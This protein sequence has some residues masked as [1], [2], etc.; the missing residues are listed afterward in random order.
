MCRQIPK[1][2]DL[3][4]LTIAFVTL[5]QVCTKT[6]A[7]DLPPTSTGLSV[8][9]DGS[10]ELQLEVFVNGTSSELIATFRQARDG[11]LLI[12]PDQLRNVGIKPVTAAVVQD[13]PDKGWIDVSR[14]SGVNVI[15]KEDNQTINFDA[16]EISRAARVVDAQA[17]ETPA[18][19]DDEAEKAATSNFGGL[20]NYTIYGATG[21]QDW[22]DLT[23]FQGVSGLLEGR[24]FGP[25]G[26]LSSSQILSSSDSDRF[27]STRLDTR[28]SYSDQERLM[29]YNVGDIITGGLSWTRPAR[30]GGI[31]IRRNFALRPDLVTMPLPE[32]SGSAAVPSTVDVYID[33]AR[34]VSRSVPAGPFSI[35][36]LPV[37]TGNGTARLVV[38]DALGRETVSETPFYASSTLLARGLADFS[39][40]T[41]FARRYYGTE[42]N[43]YDDTIVGSATLRFGMTNNLTLE[44]HVE[45]ASNFYNA[46]A[47]SI[48]SIGA[49]GVGAVSGAAS[50]FGSET[51]YQISASLEAELWKIKFFARTQRTFGDYNDIAS[52]TAEIAKYGLPSYSAKP[53]KSI[54]QVSISLPPILDDTNINFSFAQIETADFDKS[55]ILGMTVSRRFGEKGNTF[56]SAYTD[57]ARKDSFGVFAGLSWS[58]DSNMTA[59][60]S[61]SSDE[62]GATGTAEIMKSEQMEIGS[63][64]WRLRGSY[65]ENNIASAS[66][67]YRSHIGRIEGGVEKFNENVRANAQFDG[68]IV[69]AAGG[70][71]FA[72]RIDDAFGV[73]DVGAP[74]VEVQFENRPMG[75]TN[76]KGK[77]LLPN[78]RSYE[79]NTITI[80][81][82]NLPLD[83]S[84]SE[85]R[86][87]VRPSDRGAAVV[88]FNV[89]TDIRAALVTLRDEEGNYVE[90]GSTAQLNGSGEFV[91]GYDGQVYIEG[92]ADSN[93]LIVRRPGKND[94][95]A[96]FQASGKTKE[97]RVISDAP[98]R[99]TP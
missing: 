21:G 92:I 57:L 80:D 6:A 51:G 50:K 16:T 83:A 14:L 40:E 12:E 17:N 96:V 86:Q 71:F 72:N 26:V 85:T 45:G 60:A 2:V 69:F 73:V 79:R 19:E 34:R 20:V 32:L 78:L 65:G 7:Q 3:V 22:V 48:F 68:A 30:L 56:I 42:S 88:D 93:E 99:S 76:K 63:T 67:S 23:E 66:G 74:D 90:T 94:C 35:T 8:P 5:F 33:N 47:G 87:I 36:N 31:Q 89:Q 82:A 62:R 41:G 18:I 97:R 75:R 52:V 49:F 77:M 91:V 29:T 10:M 98:C 44:G 58:L 55:R 13:G 59:T 37:V 61:V 15:Y 46:G 81:P 24:L 39:A 38:R 64:G 25:Y 54:D 43:N 70:V 4:I 9:E 95:K 1:A 27:G 53:A 84:V 11:S 28:W